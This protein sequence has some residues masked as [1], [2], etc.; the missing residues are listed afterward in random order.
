MS[1]V[2]IPLLG[3][4]P[5]DTNPPQL[6][7]AGNRAY[8]DFDSST[9]ELVYVSFRLPSDY[10]SSPVL[11]V[12]WGGTS[13]TTV[14]HDVTWACEVMALTPDVDGDP[15]TDSYDTANTVND[16]ILGT[17]A[18]RIQEAS[19]TL[20][21]FD[22]G[23]ANDYIGLKIYRDVSADDLPEDARLWALSLEYTAS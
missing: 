8:W 15:D 17:T 3:L 2:P 1:T 19:I 21:N 7:F 5:D 6:G 11:K 10:S 13:S 16:A 20:T 9:D 18:G 23:A 14:S 4:V 22:S 12:Q